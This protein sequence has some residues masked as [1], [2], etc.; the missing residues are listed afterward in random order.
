MNNAGGSIMLLYEAF[1]ALDIA[2]QRRREADQDRLAALARAGQ[3]EN[4]RSI[5]RSTAV[6]LA[7]ISTAAASLVRRL[8]ECIAD[9][10]AERLGSD[11]VAT[12]H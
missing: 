9:D 4:N 2:E 7:S 5:R 6:A 11:R 10:L 12:S 8:D 1:V 3:P